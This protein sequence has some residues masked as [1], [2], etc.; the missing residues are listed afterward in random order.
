MRTA[1][2]V[3]QPESALNDAQPTPDTAKIGLTSY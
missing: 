2:V 1:T 3:S